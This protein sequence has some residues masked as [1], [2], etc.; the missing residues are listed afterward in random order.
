LTLIFEKNRDTKKIFFLIFGIVFIVFLF[1]SDGHRFT[2]DEDMGEQM[3]LGMATLEPHPDFVEGG[4]D[5]RSKNLFNMGEH[6]NPHNAGPL[7]KNAITCFPTSV[8]Y[9]ATEVPFIALNHY[10][11]IITSDTHVFSTD[12]FA[13]AHY[14]FWRNSENPNLVFLELF[15][16]PFFLALFVGIFFLICLEHKFTRQNSIILSF[17]LAFSTIIWA[18]SNTSLNVVPAAFFVLLGYLFFKK[19]RRLNQSKFLLLTAAAFGFAFLIREDSIL[20]IVPVWLFLLVNILKRLVQPTSHKDQPKNVGNKAYRT[21]RA[22]LN[23]KIHALLFYSVPLLISYSLYKLL[24]AYDGPLRYIIPEVRSSASMVKTDLGAELSGFIFSST[25]SHLLAAS[26][27]M[28]FSPGVGLFIFAPILVTVFFSF[29]DFFRKNKSECLLLL[30]FF[31][32]NIIYHADMTSWHG[33][34]SWGSRYLLMVVP[35]LLIP[36]GASLEKRNKK[37]MLS[38]ILILGILGVLFNLSYVIQD[39]HW[40]VWST[41]GSPVGLY[42]LGLPQYGQFN[43]WLN[44]VVIWT[45]QFSQLTHSLSLMFTGL[46]HDI[47]LLHVFGTSAYLVIFV[48][49]LSFLFYLFRRVTKHNIVSTENSKPVEEQ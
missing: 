21:L 35:F 41:P 13:D 22:L 17:L 37:F 31:V 15:Y 33:L 43:L 7:C 39:V 4:T 6:Y 40:F 19:F 10:F 30:S 42:A 16:S 26:Y 5:W 18:Y 1:T 48:S 12:D 36:L 14:V 44:D 28:L 9:S 38:L 3:A 23:S 32:L 46:Q 34:T 25:I 45:F 11:H 2:M 8:F 29:P 47:Y 24:N 27:G 20:F 49:L